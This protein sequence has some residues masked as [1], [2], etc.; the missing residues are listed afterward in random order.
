[1]NRQV[2]PRPFFFLLALFLLS[3]CAAITPSKRNPDR[4]LMHL[5][6]SQDMDPDYSTGNLPVALQSP[7]I[8]DGVVLVGH[9]DGHMMAFDAKS[10]R[11]LWSARDRGSYHAYPV[12]FGD[13]AVYGTVEGRVF[14]RHFLTGKLKYSVDLGAP[15]ESPGTVYKGRI[16]FHLRN[17][18]I[19]C[20]DASTGKIIWG[21]KRS[22]AQLSTLQGVSS[23]VILG[24]KLIVGLADG[25]VIALSFEDGTVLWEKKIASAGKFMDV[26]VRPVVWNNLVLVGAQSGPLMAL[27][28]KNGHPLH[29]LDVQLSRVFRL[30]RRPKSQLI[31][32][33][34]YGTLY[35]LDEKLNVMFKR[36]VSDNAIT[37]MR[38]WKRKYVVGTTG[39]EL[40]M[41][42]R[43]DFRP[44]ATFDMGHSHSSLL[45]RISTGSGKMAILSSRNRLY[46]FR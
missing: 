27:D 11:R 33:D 32:G 2:S 45:G 30:G 35:R 19:F 36:K 16:F 5:V 37:S 10:G 9:N 40:L 38:T 34:I 20:V 39:Q 12:Y 14:S 41:V 1:M 43:R 7:S 17:H 42:S 24:D 3:S 8:H 31:I 46:I 6:W 23:P 29:Q 13:Q 21:H 28:P 25:S 18:Q 44:L 22:I 4:S 15:V 26:D